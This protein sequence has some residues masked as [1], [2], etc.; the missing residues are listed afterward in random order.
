VPGTTPLIAQ[1]IDAIE[2]NSRLQSHLI[3]DLLDFAGIQ[4]GK[5]R[6]D[7]GV[8]DP[9]AAIRAALAVVE[10]QALAKGVQIQSH[11]GDGVARVLGDEPR[12]Q[13][14]V[15]N[16]LSNA[17][18]FTPKGG[19]IEL[20]TEVSDD[21]FQIEVADTGQ[22]IDPEFLPRIFDR[23]SQQDSGA[24]KSFA[25]LG[26]GLTI[27]RHLV[28]AHRGTI[29]AFSAGQGQGATFRVRLPLTLQQ[30][31]AAAVRESALLSGIHVLVVE[32][33]MDARALV[34]RLLNDAGARVSE[35]AGAD[36][37]LAQVGQAVPHVLVS[38]IGMAKRDGYQ[39][40][41][42]LR[43]G[44]HSAERL[45]A[46]ALTAFTRPEDRLDAL[47]AGFQ[48]H[49]AKPVDAEALS[50]A[51]ARLGRPLVPDGEPV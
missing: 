9:A 16:L 18:K 32:D 26:I 8:I 10:P 48:I 20:S 2:R 33:D 15:W 11:I 19:R 21:L 4:F 36:E 6:F 12:L 41:R 37:A 38:D 49:L 23:F 44:G 25:G 50:A 5:M 40:M 46:I 34:A 47:R 22:G 30:T 14:V 29:E 51:V 24:A 13:Q 1:G 17:I 42:A 45:P 7:L 35:A 28:E 3:A 39:L 31:M 43:A 27:V